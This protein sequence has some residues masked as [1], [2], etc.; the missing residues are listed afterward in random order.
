M[1]KKNDICRHWQLHIIVK[2]IL[3]HPSVT[4]HTKIPFAD[5]KMLANVIYVYR[6]LP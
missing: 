5:I 2:N 4:F 1:F 3:S 6:I